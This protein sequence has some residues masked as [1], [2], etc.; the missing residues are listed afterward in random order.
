MGSQSWQD[1]DK[2][3]NGHDLRSHYVHIKA[4]ILEAA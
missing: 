4:Q 1:K 3:L 2:L